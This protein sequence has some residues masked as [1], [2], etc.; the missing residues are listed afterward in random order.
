MTFW[1]GLV[2]LLIPWMIVAINGTYII[3]DLLSSLLILCI[4]WIFIR[5]ILWVAFRKIEMTVKGS[6]NSKVGLA[7]FMAMSESAREIQK[8]LNIKETNNSESYGKKI[9]EIKKSPVVEICFCLLFAIIYTITVSFEIDYLLA[10][11]RIAPRILPILI[12][13]FAIIAFIYMSK[14]VKGAR[15]EL[16]ENMILIFDSKEISSHVL[17]IKDIDF[18]HCA[19]NRKDC[20]ICMYNQQKK[21]LLKKYQYH[22]LEEIYTYRDLLGISKA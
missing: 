21:V 15:I 7:Y 10:P 19:E 14:R 6:N 5:F 2:S 12:M 13:I 22:N 4:F 9:G 17:S 20:E 8:S 11:N 3:A 1:I 18:I 16:Y